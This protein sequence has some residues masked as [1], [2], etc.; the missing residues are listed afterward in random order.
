MTVTARYVD[1]YDHTIVWPEGMPWP[2]DIDEHQRHF[3]MTHYP[4]PWRLLRSIRAL[5]VEKGPDGVILHGDRTMHDPRAEGYAQF[6]RVSIGGRM[7]RAFTSD[8]LV[9][10]PD[11]KLYTFAILYVCSDPAPADAAVLEKKL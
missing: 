6:G 1:Q 2:T 10:G 7:R 11:G 5:A 3:T 9:Q 8:Q 4:G